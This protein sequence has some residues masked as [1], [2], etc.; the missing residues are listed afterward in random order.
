MVMYMAVPAAATPS[1]RFLAQL[2]DEIQ[3]DQHIKR[4]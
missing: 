4:R 3:V 2:R 1:H